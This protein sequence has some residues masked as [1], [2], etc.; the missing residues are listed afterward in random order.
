MYVMATR[1]TDFEISE[2]MS[3]CAIYMLYMALAPR[4]EISSE[5]LNFSSLK[6]LPT[7]LECNFDNAAL[8]LF[9][10]S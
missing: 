5:V 8:K 6:C 10:V 1:H 2:A 4:Q 3:T 9:P 7:G